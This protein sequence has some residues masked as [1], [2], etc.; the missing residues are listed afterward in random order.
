MKQ[1]IL[2]Y[3]FS[4]VT[5]KDID[6]PKQLI[7]C[8]DRDGKE[9]L[10]LSTLYLIFYTVTIYDQ[11]CISGWQHSLAYKPLELATV[12]RIKNSIYLGLNHSRSCVIRLS[13]LHLMPRRGK[14]T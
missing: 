6:A 4:I 9:K 13:H 12:Y 3:H 14:L 7:E 2:N 1:V 10:P 11:T 8:F 5:C